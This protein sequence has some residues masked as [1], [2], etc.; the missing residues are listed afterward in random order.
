M[1]SAPEPRIRWRIAS[2]SH[3]ITDLLHEW[4]RGDER[5]L[6][7]LI[8]L[9]HRELHRLARR[10]LA[11]ER[12]DQALQATELVNETYLRLIGAHAVSWTDRV[13]FLA[14]AARVMRRILVDHAR[15]RH[16]GKRAG[17]AEFIEVDETALVTPSRQD[18]AALDDALVALAAFDERKSRVVE[19]RFFGG[20]TVE[21]TAAAVH[22]SPDT[23]MRDW[24]LARAWLRQQL[25]HAS[26]GSRHTGRARRTRA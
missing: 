2:G 18:L 16:A 21:E 5:A 7:R 25:D 15:A 10:H 20:L 19:L 23:V 9:V 13:H 26:D 24:R 3:E 4:T 22:V 1:R 17:S 8:P 14:I 6:D 12:P 11:R